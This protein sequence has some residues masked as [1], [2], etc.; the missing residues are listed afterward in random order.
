MQDY[1]ETNVGWSSVDMEYW[2]LYGC[3][4]QNFFDGQI[5]CRDF[6]AD[7]ISHNHIV[8]AWTVRL[9]PDIA[10]SQFS[11]YQLTGF[12]LSLGRGHINTIVTCEPLWRAPLKLLTS[13]QFSS[14]T[15]SPENATVPTPTHLIELRTVGSILRRSLWFPF[16]HHW[17]SPHPHIAALPFQN[18]HLHPHN[19]VL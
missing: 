3:L 14:I 19:T 1:C 12:T 18:M 7:A 4:L 16:S 2:Y 11:Y 17:R 9:L 6:L 15:F 5:E 10:T 13:D 8:P